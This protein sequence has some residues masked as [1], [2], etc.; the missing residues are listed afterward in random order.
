MSFKNTFEVPV[1][2]CPLE[3]LLEMLWRLEED[4]PRE[5]TLREDGRWQ[6]GDFG[7]VNG[8]RR[9]D[10]AEVAAQDILMRGDLR[11]QTLLCVEENVASAD[12]GKAIALF[13]ENGFFPSAQGFLA[14]VLG[15]SCCDSAS[16]SL[17]DGNGK[18]VIWSVT[19]SPGSITLEST[20]SRSFEVLR[21]EEV[22]R[23]SGGLPVLGFKI[24]E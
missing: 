7:W 3:E 18:S 19:F 17:P 11:G 22:V 9:T 13:Q 16:L 10:L 12:A 6:L 24:K 23:I 14:A 8:Y 1:P 20:D 2:D 21:L 4:Q 5:N 15:R